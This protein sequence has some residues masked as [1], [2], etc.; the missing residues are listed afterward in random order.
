MQTA[1]IHPCSIN[2][3][4]YV[5]HTN[6]LQ[7]TFESYIAEFEEMVVQ[8]DLLKSAL[9]SSL[10]FLYTHMHLGRNFLLERNG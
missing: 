1:E 7:H 3:L 5:S 10:L 4:P 9:N 6:Q 2:D 8:D